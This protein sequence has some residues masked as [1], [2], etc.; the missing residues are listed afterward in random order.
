MEAIQKRKIREIARVDTEPVLVLVIQVFDFGS[1]KGA[2]GKEND[3]VEKDIAVPQRAL[4]ET[5][6][7]GTRIR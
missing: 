6:T 7:S 1:R 4:P 5:N 3:V 2:A